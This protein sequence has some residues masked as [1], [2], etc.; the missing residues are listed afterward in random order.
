VQRVDPGRP[1]NGEKAPIG[2]RCFDGAL[3]LV[4][5]RAEHRLRQRNQELAYRRLAARTGLQQRGGVIEGHL[6]LAREALFHTWWTRCDLG[7]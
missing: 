4:G 6:Q 2:D 5:Q 1:G 3:L 7:C